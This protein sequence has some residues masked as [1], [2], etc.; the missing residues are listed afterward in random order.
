[1]SSLPEFDKYGRFIESPCY[2]C[3]INNCS[4]CPKETNNYANKVGA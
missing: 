2:R 1:M 3:D 4:H